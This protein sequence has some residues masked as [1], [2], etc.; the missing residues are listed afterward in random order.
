MGLLSAVRR[1]ASDANPTADNRWTG[2]NRGGFASPA[3]DRLGEQVRVTLE[4][5][6]R[7]EQERELVRIFSADLPVLPLYYEIQMVPV[8]Q[9]LTGVQPIRGIAHTGHVMH[10]WNVHEWDLQ[11]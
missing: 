7:V 10:T 1:F 9:G 5:G 11:R 2:T 4:E 6:K 8:A 3:W